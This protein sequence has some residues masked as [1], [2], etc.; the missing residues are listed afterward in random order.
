M[1]TERP[2]PGTGSRGTEPAGAGMPGE[3]AGQ[4]EDPG[5]TGVHPASAGWPEGD[6]K[7]VR[8]GEWGQGERGLA[9]Y[10]DH[11]ESELLSLGLVEGD[12]PRSMISQ[13]DAE[14]DEQ[15]PGGRESNVGPGGPGPREGARPDA[16]ANG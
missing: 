11:G 10:E 15:G 6:M 3:G 4:R 7:I 9:G 13:P 16:D 8:E 1:T 14:S 2:D 12:E 5:R